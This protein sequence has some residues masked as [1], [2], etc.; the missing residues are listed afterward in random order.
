MSGRRKKGRKDLAGIG[1]FIPGS[2]LSLAEYRSPG[3][4]EINLL[5]FAQSL[6]D[7]DRVELAS[8]SRAIKRMRQGRG[9]GIDG[10]QVVC[11]FT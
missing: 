4:W 11:E 8:L 6:R 5:E 3:D 10:E 2:R 7:G 9:G 1:V